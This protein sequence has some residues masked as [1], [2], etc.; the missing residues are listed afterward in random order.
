MDYRSIFISYVRLFE[1]QRHCE[2]E[3]VDLAARTVARYRRRGVEISLRSDQRVGGRVPSAISMTLHPANVQDAHR[4]P[5]PDV[6][7][8]RVGSRGGRRLHVRVRVRPAGRSNTFSLYCHF[9]CRP[10][11]DHS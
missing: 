8:G 3:E 2:N 9:I 6:S 5:V 7:V 4:T 1:I 10:L 11:A